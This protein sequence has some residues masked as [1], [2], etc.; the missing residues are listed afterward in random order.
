MVDQYSD[1][2]EI[3]ITLLVLEIQ[4][5]ESVFRFFFQ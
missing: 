3:M 4:D 5:F 1:V 2:C